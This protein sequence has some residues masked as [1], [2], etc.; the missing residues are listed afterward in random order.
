MFVMPSEKSRPFAKAGVDFGPGPCRVAAD[1]TVN[2]AAYAVRQITLPVAA[3]SA[4]MTSSSP[5][6]LKT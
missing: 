6:R 4:D 1:M 3:S 5:C 2:G